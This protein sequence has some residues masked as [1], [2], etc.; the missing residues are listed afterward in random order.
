[1]EIIPCSEEELP[2]IIRQLSRRPYNVNIIPQF[3]GWNPLVLT[4]NPN[5]KYYK[6]II[7]I[8]KKVF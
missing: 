6:S 7:L 2:Q 1:M 4:H 8:P 5:E 3:V